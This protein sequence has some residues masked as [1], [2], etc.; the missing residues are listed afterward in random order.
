MPVIQHPIINWSL[1]TELQL[2][3]KFQAVSNLAIQFGGSDTDGT[4]LSRLVF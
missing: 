4:A 3:K 2:S 1:S